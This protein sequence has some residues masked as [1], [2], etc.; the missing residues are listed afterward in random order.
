MTSTVMH[1]LGESEWDDLKWR[2]RLETFGQNDTP[3]ITAG[4]NGSLDGIW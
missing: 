4:P 1:S 2:R 3:I